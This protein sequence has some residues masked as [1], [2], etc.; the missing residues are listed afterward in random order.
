[1]TTQEVPEELEAHSPAR[2]EG[3]LF[4]DEYYKLRL[5]G[6]TR[7]TATIEMSIDQADR[8][9]STR[10]PSSSRVQKRRRGKARAAMV[11]PIYRKGKRVGPRLSARERKK[12]PRS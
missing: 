1:M 12:S 11:F 8:P 6:L 2:E 9:S 3:T 4:V 5:E 7:L 10:E